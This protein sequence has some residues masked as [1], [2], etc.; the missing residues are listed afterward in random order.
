MLNDKI[1]VYNS[2]AIETSKNTL[3]YSLC[4]CLLFNEI[5]DEG[6]TVSAW[7]LGRQGARNDPNNIGTCE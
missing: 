2:E 1:A 6:R 3:S 4:L 5:R 7:K